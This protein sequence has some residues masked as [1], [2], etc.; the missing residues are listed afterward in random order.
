[1][2][3]LILGVDDR[4]NVELDILL[5]VLDEGRVGEIRD[6]DVTCA[7]E[8]RDESGQASSGS[9]LEDVFGSTCRRR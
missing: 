3:D 9:Q 2:G 4:I 5:E 1:M 6:D 7:F 8:R